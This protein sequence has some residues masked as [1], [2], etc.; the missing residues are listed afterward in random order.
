MNFVTFRSMLQKHI[1]EVVKGSTHLFTV[2]VDKDEMWN[3]YLDSFLPEHNKIFRERREHDCSCCRHWVKTFG[4]VV[5]IKNNK[6]VSIWDF[7]TN[8]DVFQP[9]LTAMSSFIHSKNIEDVFVTDTNKFGTEH[10]FER[11]ENGDIQ[12]DHFYCEIP[13]SFVTRDVDTLDTVKGRMRDIR[14]VFKRSL[15]EISKE[16]IDT[17]LELIYQNSLYKGE[18]W[19]TTL[20]KFKSLFIQYHS[21]SDYEKELYTWAQSVTVGP[22]VGKIRNHSIG[23]LLTNIT[24]GEELDVAVRKYEAVVAPTNYKRPKAIFTKKMVEDAKKT[25]EQLGYGNSLER[26]FATIDDI[27]IP[28]I[29]FGNRDVVKK[30]SK[31][32]FDDLASEVATSPKAFNKVEEVSI[33]TFEKD[34]LPTAKKIEI[35]VEN[36]HKMS[37]VSLITSKVENSKNM[38]KWG[39]NASWAYTGNITDSTK[40]LVKNAGGKVDGVLRFS[41][42]WNDEG[43]NSIDFDA[44]CKEPDGNEIYYG[45]KVNY[46]TKGNLDVDIISPGSSVAV[47][48]ITWPTQSLMREGTY[49]F[50][51]HNFSS[52]ES[53]GG[54]SAQIEFD[55]QIHEFEYNKNLRGR[56][57]IEVAYVNYSKDKGFSI[58]EK[59]PSTTSSRQ[60]WGINTNN[61]YP[62]SVCMYSPNYWD[63]QNGIGHKHYFFMIEGCKNDESPNG[64]F[65][66]YLNEELMKHKRVFEALGSRMKVDYSDNQ[67]SGLGFSSTKR[68]EL[69]CKVEGSFTRTIKILF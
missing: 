59:L 29:L 43:N 16:S 30:L 34:I 55:G 3:L 44:H 61:F 52:R 48:N 8:E 67:L 35:L 53:N 12:W 11:T 51:I 69:I 46:S 68:N 33:E 57:I 38:F 65:N 22:V 66:E 28:N 41:I 31:D 62:V 17:V 54:F 21:L 7:S 47:E 19:K 56:E 14:N 10:N 50:F 64:F 23:T 40:E 39:N 1:S 63:K 5:A 6:V 45:Q 27:T 15:D 49:K 24:L 13:S 32:V 18:E 20:E 26:R 42:R 4:N 37:F 9:V 60:V 36:K 58:V 25:I 2:N